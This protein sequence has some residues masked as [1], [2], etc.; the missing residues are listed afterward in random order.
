M[1]K[2]VLREQQQS[3][4]GLHC[5]QFL[6]QLLDPLLYSKT[7]LFQFKDNY[8]NFWVSKFLGVLR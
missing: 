4:Q 2:P 7:K 1:R 8:S 5:L 3:E 6:P